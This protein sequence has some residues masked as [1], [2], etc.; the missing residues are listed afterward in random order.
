MFASNE[1]FQIHTDVHSLSSV[2][3]ST[4]CHL[5]KDLLACEVVLYLGNG[6]TQYSGSQVADECSKC[7]Q[8]YISRLW[9][10]GRE[11]KWARLEY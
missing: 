3:L 10:S 7:I 11:T 6:S 5:F 1:S 8:I 4:S 2:T 9:E